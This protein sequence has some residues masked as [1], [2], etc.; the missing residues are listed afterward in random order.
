MI[1]RVLRDIR[2]Q[3]PKKAWLGLGLRVFK[4]Y[5]AP[6]SIVLWESPDNPYQT[7]SRTTWGGAETVKIHMLV[8]GMLLRLLTLTQASSSSRRALHRAVVGWF[9]RDNGDI[10]GDARW[11]CGSMQSFPKTGG[12]NLGPKI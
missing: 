8:H 1:N 11:V 10:H 7:P 6:F 2:S 5:W 3:M 12:L 9:R 4:R